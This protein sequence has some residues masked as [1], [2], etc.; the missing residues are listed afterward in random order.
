[1]S[2][3]QRPE[4]VVSKR[5]SDEDVLVRVSRSDPAFGVVDIEAWEGA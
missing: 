5:I 1:M 3:S 4:Q 2:R